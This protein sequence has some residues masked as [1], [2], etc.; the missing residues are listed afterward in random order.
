MRIF[1][2]ASLK[3][4]STYQVLAIQL[5]FR[6]FGITMAFYFTLVFIF[7]ILIQSINAW[8]DVGH[9]TVAYV[10]RHYLDGNGKAFLSQHLSSDGKSWELFN[11]STWPDKIKR[12]YPKTRPWHYVSE[13]TQMFYCLGEVFRVLLTWFILGQQILRMTLWIIHVALHR[14]QKTAKLRA[15]FFPRLKIW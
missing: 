14:F 7:A 12:K 9:G 1:H 3:K 5:S 13:F 4:L 11:A 8:G 10:A 2:C 15:A 6:A